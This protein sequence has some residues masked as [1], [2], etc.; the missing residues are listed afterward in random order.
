M[1]WAGTALLLSWLQVLY[2]V[3]NRRRNKRRPNIALF[4]SD[5]FCLLHAVMSITIA[6]RPNSVRLIWDDRRI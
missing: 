2:G 3:L 4:I 1:A 5:V 6:L